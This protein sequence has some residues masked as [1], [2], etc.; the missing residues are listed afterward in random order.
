MHAQ[1]IHGNALA[2]LV[3]PVSPAASYRSLEF[4]LVS[5]GRNRTPRF[6]A[7]DQRLESFSK[8][9]VERSTLKQA[10]PTRVRQWLHPC[11]PPPPTSARRGSARYV[12]REIDFSLDHRMDV[13]TPNH[14]RTSGRLTY[15][16]IKYFTE[17]GEY[18][19][20]RY[21]LLMIVTG[22]L[23]SLQSWVLS[24]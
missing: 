11:R 4:F 18:H 23:R 3:I 17:I 9:T 15:L 22:I 14:R 7:V 6:W 16:R 21:I 24:L 1:A 19:H 12:R 8:T 13:T 20:K 2:A 5:S 10:T